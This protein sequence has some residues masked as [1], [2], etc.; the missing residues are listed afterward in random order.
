MNRSEGFTMNLKAAMAMNDRLLAVIQE[1]EDYKSSETMALTMDIVKA[2][3]STKADPVSV[4]GRL[5][6]LAVDNK[7][8]VI[9]AVAAALALFLEV[10]ETK[11]KKSGNGK[12]S[13]SKTDKERL[14]SWG[15]VEP[16]DA[17]KSYRVVYALPADD[18]KILSEVDLELER[19]PKGTTGDQVFRA[20]LFDIKDAY[21]DQK[22]ANARRIISL[23]T[24][25]SSAPAS[26]WANSISS[27]L[28]LA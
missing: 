20:Y 24:G 3:R 23:M 14:A 4:F 18:Q 11:A 19:V 2:I 13:L 1:A 15:Y 21:S 7:E 25:S 9:K 16:T 22:P 26:L 8:T 28:K 12:V 10:A 5:A 17:P 6:V 27:D